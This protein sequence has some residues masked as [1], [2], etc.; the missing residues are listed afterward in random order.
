MKSVFEKKCAQ[1]PLTTCL[2]VPHTVDVMK[3]YFPLSALG[4]ISKFIPN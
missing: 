3:F 2:C 1:N 4:R